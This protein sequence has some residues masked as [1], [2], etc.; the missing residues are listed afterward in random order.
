[1]L[2]R[3]LVLLALAVVPAAVGF[4][5][6]RE[7][8][9]PNGL[10]VVLI[11]HHANPMVASTV[12][13]GAGVTE[14]RPDR[15]GASHLLEHL[16]FNGTTTRS[17]RALYDATD[18]VGAYNNATT[19][20][21]HTLFTL[22]VQREFAGA[23]LD[24]QADMLF[25]STIPAENFDKEKGIVLEE[26]ARDASDPGYA[27][28]Q[29]FRAFAYA[30]TPL[31]LPVLG[32]PESI[33]SIRRDEV[34]A[35]WKE[36]YVP[37]NMLLVV[38]G[39]FETQAML[40]LVRRT[41]GAAPAA[42]LPAG[43]AGAWP[44]PPKDNLTVQRLDAPRT[45][46][47][48][49]FPLGLAAN[50]PLVPAVE[51]LLDALAGGEDAPLQEA[52]TSGADP[53]A[54]TLGLA[55]A[56]RAGPWTTVELT[57]TL[58]PGKPHLPVLD[59]L[60]RALSDLGPGSP[61][62]ARLPLVRAAARARE[63]LEADQIHYFALNRGAALLQA[64]PGWLARSGRRYDG[65]LDEELERAAAL[66][67]EGL[68]GARIAVMGPDLGDRSGRWE[69]RIEAPAPP[70]GRVDRVFPNGMRAIV[71]ASDDSAVCAVH[72]A[73]RPRAASEPRD[74]A[75]MASLLHH[76]LPRGTVEL[77]E[78]A[79]AVRLARLGAS[80][81]TDDD[82][83]VPYDD[84]YTTPEFSFVRLELP[85]DNW[86]EG[87]ALLGDVL[88]RPR[89]DDGDLAAVLG[90]MQDLQARRSAASRN[91][92]MDALEAA[93]APDHPL[94]R[95]VLGT[96]GSLQGVTT[97]ELRSFHRGY[98]TGRRLLVTV[99]SP[100]PP[101]AVLEALHAAFGNLPEGSVPPTVPPPPPT[102]TGGKERRAATLAE[103]VTI[104]MGYVFDAPEADRAA[105]AVLGAMLSDALAF[106]L[107]E[108][109][110]LAYTV[111]AS[112]APWG[113]RMRLL[114]TMGTRKANLDEALVLLRAGI[115]GFVPGDPAAVARA[116]ASLRG[117]MLMRRLTRINQAYFLAMDALA[118]QAP[119]GER[120][121]LDALLRVDREA[122][123]AA[124]LRYIDAGKC[125]VVA[126]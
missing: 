119:G 65:V 102:G 68:K 18:R 85:A 63:I 41:F 78:A 116:A 39:D 83:S 27:A 16:L 52:L 50:D 21:D 33:A 69:P 122:V 58:P 112:I 67:Q 25:R 23:G 13:V 66:L 62:R 107:R 115:A 54:T 10:R 79:F 77:D 95:P 72:V 51:L 38:M 110:G 14:E 104:A 109:R 1:M 4:A 70:R 120:E 29:R 15:S 45:Y 74:R 89:L 117:R 99:E 118:G 48:A 56:P 7:E 121:R 11:E 30:G 125:V 26:M 76:L 22:L 55:L 100:V 34:V 81:K 92:A 75:G 47:Q 88:V 103:Q 123:A 126:E 32:T 96:A 71:E 59:A 43:K 8:T 37:G 2:P 19:R 87:I 6:Y 57:A 46:V 114:V 35:Y 94:T 3:R 113:G 12:V 42:P 108:T 36:R 111:G 105:L 5:A 80:L 91:R 106:D 98:V 97:D 64:P 73:L 9:L 60:A 28:W 20:E 24:L 40:D 49:A 61:A 31:A 93:L 90:Q 44:A 101:Q 84:Y 53:A 86:R 17:Q 82:P 124:M